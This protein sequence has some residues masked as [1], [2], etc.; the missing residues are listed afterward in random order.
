MANPPINIASLDF[1][2]IKNSLVNYLRS[3]ENFNSYNFDSTALS[4]LLDVLAY[5]TMFYGYYAN[6]IANESFLETSQIPDNILASIKPLG[7]VINGVNASKAIL[8]ITG[9]DIILTPYTSIF[10]GSD[11]AGNNFNFYTTKQYILNSVEPVEVTIYEAANIV[12]DKQISGEGSPATGILDLE[13]QSYRVGGFDIDIYT[14]GVQVNGEYWSLY[15]AYAPKIK[16]STDKIY[17]IERRPD[18]FY[19]LFSKPG[20][21]ETFSFPGARTITSSDIVKISYIIPSGS[22][23]N[24]STI[25]SGSGTIIESSLSSGGGAPNIDLIKTFAPKLFASSDRAITKDDYYSVIMNSGFLPDDI[26]TQEQ[27]LVWGGEELNTPIPGKVYYSLA[28]LDIT[29]DMVKTLTSLLKDKGVIT[30]TPEF[31]PPKFITIYSTFRY[32]GIQPLSII[33]NAI[34]KFYN[35]GYKFNKLFSLS[36]FIIYINNTF[37]STKL[38]DIIATS[39]ELTITSFS[40]IVN[41]NNQLKLPTSSVPGTVLT[42]DRFLLP[43]GETCIFKDKLVSGNIG[44]IIIQDLSGNI[45]G[46]AGSINYET[47]DLYIDKNHLTVG[48]VNL[49]ISPRNI[50]LLNPGLATVYTLIPEITT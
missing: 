24:G 46:D 4:T 39:I 48:G 33:K 40:N 8:Q 45:L 31:V 3:Q 26:T 21:N 27:I 22:I 41:L 20:L 18:G 44:K 34:Q 49:R 5:N 35:D 16:S 25:T 12:K 30:V 9:N 50:K 37:S 14:I 28:K 17:F 11:S 36:D 2:E 7:Y 13:S 43:S 47:G 1:R 15:N 19:L 23:A 42:S 38:L 10:F 29:S 32:S 6:I